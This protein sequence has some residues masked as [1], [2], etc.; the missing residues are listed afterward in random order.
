MSYGKQ[1][2]HTDN[3]SLIKNKNNCDTWGEVPI[4]NGHV[5]RPRYRTR[6]GHIIQ[7][8][9][10]DTHVLILLAQKAGIATL[11]DKKYMS[12]QEY[13][14]EKRF[15]FWKIMKFG[16]PCKVNVMERVIVFE[17]GRNLIPREYREFRITDKPIGK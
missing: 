15:A 2:R 5:K 1:W 4:F 8:R 7:K 16:E 11:M 3:M 17:G 9:I 10:D 14:N 6:I 13:Y 12:E